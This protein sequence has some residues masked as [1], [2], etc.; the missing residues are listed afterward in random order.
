MFLTQ[1]NIDRCIIHN[2][3]ANKAIASPDHEEILDAIK[4][5]PSAMYMLKGYAY[6]G[7]GRRVIR[8]EI[9]SNHGNMFLLVLLVVRYRSI[10]VES[11]SGDY[12]ALHG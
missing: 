10:Y 4:F 6:V 1:R 5:T 8:L 11:Q 7:G 9:S 3:N 2:L 12:A